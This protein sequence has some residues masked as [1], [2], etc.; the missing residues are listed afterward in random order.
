MNQ[1][2]QSEVEKG[3]VPF[4]RSC[5]IHRHRT[6]ENQAPRF[7]G[8]EVGPALLGLLASSHPV[9]D[10]HIKLRGHKYTLSRLR[11][12]RDLCQYDKVTGHIKIVVLSPGSCHGC[13][14]G[15][16]V[17]HFVSNDVIN[18]SADL[19]EEMTVGYPES[20]TRLEIDNT[21]LG[22][23]TTFFPDGSSS[24]IDLVPRVLRGKNKSS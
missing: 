14:S 21:H 7:I 12:L 22:T 4:S 15:K 5:I 10:L 11:L 23:R 2:V 1:T 9:P 3:T 17:L 24:A 20:Q 18:P 16:R 19:I 6:T 8:K 13:T